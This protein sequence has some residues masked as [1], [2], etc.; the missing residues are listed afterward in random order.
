MTIN[1]IKTSR[2]FSDNNFFLYNNDVIIK[3]ENIATIRIRS[4]KV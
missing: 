4:E 3:A 1:P 2:I